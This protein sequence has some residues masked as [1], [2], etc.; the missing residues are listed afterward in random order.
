MQ[1]DQLLMPRLG[2]E[3]IS[4]PQFGFVH[5]LT[6][7]AHGGAFSSETG[8]LRCNRRLGA[9]RVVLEVRRDQKP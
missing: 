1:L 2:I 5:L 6:L 8:L 9:R 7:A 4:S 3:G